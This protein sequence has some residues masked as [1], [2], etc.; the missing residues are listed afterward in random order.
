MIRI[1][2]ILI[3]LI[4]L[5]ALTARAL[6]N[7][8]LVSNTAVSPSLSQGELILINRAN[9]LAK[10]PLKRF[11]LVAIVPPYVD[12]K[13]YTPDDSFP[14]KITDYTGIPLGEAPILDIRR[15]IALPGETVVMRKDLGIFVDGKLLDESSYTRDEPETDL[16]VLSDI[17]RHSAFA[18]NIPMVE[19]SDAPIVVPQ[20]SAF[21]LP[22]D[23]KNF[24][25]SERWG[26]LSDDRIVGTV[27]Y[28]LSQNG[29]AA[30][31]VPT[32]SFA[33]E[34]VAI[35]D[36]GVRALDSGEYSKAIHLFK[37]ALAIDNNFELARDNLSIAYNNVA[38]KS[39]DKPDLALDS[40][41]KALFLD[42]DNELTKKNLVGILNRMG[43][44]ANKYEDRLALAEA[45]EKHGK[46]ISALVEYRAAVQLRPNPN[47]LAKISSLEQKCNFPAHA[48]PEGLVASVAPSDG[49]QTSAKKDV[50]NPE[51][52]VS[53][54]ADSKPDVTKP[55][56]SKTAD[57]KPDV[58]KPTVPKTAD[59]KP[60]V[61]KPTVPKTADSKP[62]VTK[63][64]VP[65]TADSKPKVAR[66]GGSNSIMETASDSSKPRVANE[67]VDEPAF[68]PTIRSFDAPVIPSPVPA[69]SELKKSEG[70]IGGFFHNLEA[71]MSQKNKA[72][73]GTANEGY[74]G[75]PL[76]KK[77]P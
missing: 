50:E 24:T 38:I 41:H 42:P 43:K 66:T 22:D 39:A 27:D 16:F 51:P 25:G 77:T 63:P 36:D 10:Q 37:S 72:G 70:G 69:S 56:V 52:V 55:T 47:V 18:G 29:L 5:V 7:P 71:A 53:K 33:T 4:G 6:I 40:L 31:P 35:N 28:K 12:G 8:A 11:A 19:M 65:K 48:I 75:P 14:A 74:R 9:R 1:V 13:P 61:T 45:A 67:T 30:I 58:T 54:S 26:C 73:T 60:D 21:V 59:L 46:A 34:K 64:T 57:S 15:V 76:L 32:L 44:D 49:S 62:D 3:V 2:L 20:D 68:G 17:S 23:R